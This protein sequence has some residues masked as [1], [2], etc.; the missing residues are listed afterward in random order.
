MKNLLSS[1]EKNR[2][3]KRVEG[4][5][6]EKGKEGINSSLPERKESTRSCPERKRHTTKGKGEALFSH[7]QE[8]R[9]R[10]DG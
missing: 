3:K 4:Y 9:K 5:D 2:F 10:N 6:Q 8:G 1:K 7:S